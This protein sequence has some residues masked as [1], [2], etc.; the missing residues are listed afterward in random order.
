[1]REGHQQALLAERKAVITALGRAFS[2]LLSAWLSQR[3]DGSW[4]DVILW[5]SREQAEHPTAHATEVPEAAAWFTHIDQSRGIEH[6]RLRVPLAGVRE[7]VVRHR[8]R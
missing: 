1:M 5:R 3:D 4:L 2:G 8:C 7:S 6:S